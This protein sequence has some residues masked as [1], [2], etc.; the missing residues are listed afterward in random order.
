MVI[1]HENINNR[2]GAMKNENHT[3]FPFTNMESY[4]SNASLGTEEITR[5][6]TQC[7]IHIHSLRYRLTDPDGISAKAVIDGLVKTG[8]LTDD[9]AKQVKEVTFSQEKIKKPKEEITIL[10]IKENAPTS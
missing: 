7:C 3:A 5:L 10:E 6:D 8:I 1:I 9:T 2:S 4:F